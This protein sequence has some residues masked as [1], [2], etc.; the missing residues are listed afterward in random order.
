[1]GTK[2]LF[3][4]GASSGI[5]AA[6]AR[7]AAEQGWHIGLFARS[8]DK[9][10]ALARELGNKAVALPRNVTD[11]GPSHLR[12]GKARFEEVSLRRR[13]PDAAGSFIRADILGHGWKRSWYR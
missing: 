12:I 13:G 1:M 3:I 5:G 11:F 2:A 6:M 9:L 8:K 7:L 10:D 4:T